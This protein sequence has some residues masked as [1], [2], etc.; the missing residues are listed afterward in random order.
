MSE[1][2]NGGPA[3]PYSALAPDGPSMYADSEGM[4]LRDYFAA[5]ALA[6]ISAYRTEDVE[7][8]EP[9]HFASHAYAIADAMIAARTP[10]DTDDGT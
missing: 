2:D 3:F 5:K 1:I 9:R 7:G 8:W 10:K 6:T 4:S